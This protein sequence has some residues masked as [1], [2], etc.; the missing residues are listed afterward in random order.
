MI[1]LG[2]LFLR[3]I[4]APISPTFTWLKGASAEMENQS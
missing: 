4:H 2:F 1:A 3:L